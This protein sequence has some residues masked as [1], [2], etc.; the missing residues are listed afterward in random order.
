MVTATVTAMTTATTIPNRSAAA[1]ASEPPWNRLGRP[2]LGFGTTPLTAGVL[3]ILSLG[4]LPAV[5]W[6]L[7]WATFLQRERGYYREM[8]AWWQRR[9]TPADAG[10]L[11]PVLAE[12]RP[13]PVMIMLPWLAVLFILLTLVFTVPF[14]LLDVP[15]LADAT[16][17]YG[18]LSYHGSHAARQFHQVWA[19]SLFFAYS[20]Q[21]YAVRSH[22][23]ALGVLV[24]WTNQRATAIGA[25]GVPNEAARLGLGPMWIVVGT[26]LCF[27]GSWWAIPMV[28]AGA[29]QRR[30]AELGTARL[31]A[32]LG[33]Q[34]S[35]VVAAGGGDGQSTRFCPAP[36]CGARL[37][38][39]ARFCGRCGTP[40]AVGHA[41][42]A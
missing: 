5:V 23:R 35:D 31:T 28:L 37:P 36:G 7:R 40:A 8:T 25:R 1:V 6:P 29:A 17:G 12:L 26:V 21:W 14:N 38:A 2:R 32:A 15:R 42:G 39:P 4:L 24:R 13:R 34:A 18:L 3:S 27:T 41:A 16:I 22:G 9:A 10:Q 30:Y 20:C 11:N 33:A 19:W